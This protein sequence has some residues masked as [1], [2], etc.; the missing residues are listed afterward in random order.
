MSLC[1]CGVQGDEM[2]EIPVWLWTAAGVALLAVGV[3]VLRQA[4][5]QA[6]RSHP[7]LWA[8]W[9]LVLAGL[10]AFDGG[11]GGELGTAYGLIALGL[12]AYAVVTFGIEIREN[13][14]RATREKALDPEE[15]SP[16][17]GRAIFKSILAIV[18]AGIAAIGVGLAFAVLGPMSEAD[19]IIVG[20]ILVPVLW[21]AG[22]AWT[23]CDARLVRAFFVLV[24][25]SAVSYAAAFLPKVIA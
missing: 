18:L 12:V 17:W 4:W 7:L 9:A 13:R 25:V 6:R 15:R 21:G 22:M 14:R 19:R 11:W 20:G 3:V 16:S 8:G 5:D 2:A 1:A 10:A 23:L 24:G